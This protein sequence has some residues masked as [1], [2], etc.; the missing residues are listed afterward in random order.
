LSRYWVALPGRGK[1]VEMTAN[2][3]IDR[4][5]RGDLPAGTLIAR[6]G[7][8]D[9]VQSDKLDEL[10]AKAPIEDAPRASLTGEAAPPSSAVQ[11][12]DATEAPPDLGASIGAEPPPLPAPQP[13]AD[14]R[15]TPIPTAAPQPKSRTV[16]LV[17]ASALVALLLSAGGFW[18]WFR[19]GYARGTVLEHVPTDCRRLEY[20]DFAAI[21]NVLK[22]QLARR[23]KALRDWIEDLDDEDGFRRSQDDDAKGR[24][25]TLRKL[26]GLGLK[27]YGDVKEIAVCEIRDGDESDNLIVVG[28]T[29]RGRDLPLAIREALIRR[30]RKVKDDRLT[31]EDFDGRP[32][33]KLEDNKYLMIASG[34]VAMIGKRKTITRYLQSKPA[35]RAYNIRDDEVIVRFWAPTTDGGIATGERYSIRGG[36]LVSVRTWQKGTSGTDEVKAIKDRLTVAAAKLRKFDGLDVLADA[37]ENVEVRLNGEEGQTEVSWPI[38]DVTKAMTSIYDADRRELR[39]ILDAM[40]SAQATEF[41]HHAVIPGIDYFD[42][43]LSPWPTATPL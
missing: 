12:A 41:F 24:G 35:A 37:Y 21:D 29:F 40:R 5:K 8:K 18:A 34:Q 25:S 36:K 13:E 30:D 11:G 32:T 38:K 27:P 10:L 28:G 23:D 19:Y 2:E 20:V 4:K 7:T 26:A 14:R 22:A 9:W 42:L 17:L 39:S 15:D 16:V 43:R 33:L 31:I 3:L 1:A 6:F